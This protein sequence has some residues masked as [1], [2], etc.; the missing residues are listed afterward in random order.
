MKKMM[1]MAMMMAMTVTANAMSYK[2]AKKE[3]LFLSDK[4]AYE[5]N[6]TPA[7]Y[8]DVY[9]INLDYMM[10]L[11]SRGDVYGSWWDRRDA[12][13]RCVLTPWQYDRYRGLNHFYRPVMWKSGRWAFA[14]YAHYKRGHFYNHHPKP[15]HRHDPRHAP[16]HRHEPRHH[17]PHR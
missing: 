15:H 8:D 12:K 6:L 16:H 4:M 11:N 1:L 17:G 7:Q 2:T 3:A 10:S 14:V 13:L 5:L 9:D